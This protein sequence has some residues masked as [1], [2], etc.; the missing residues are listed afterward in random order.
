MGI[1]EKF[2]DKI[3]SYNIFTSIIP[4]CVLARLLSL[5]GLYDVQVEGTVASLVL[6]YFFGVVAGRIGSLIVES[7]LLA[8]HMINYAPRKEYIKAAQEDT[9]IKKLLEVSNMY[10]TFAGVFLLLLI[11]KAYQIVAGFLNL[12]SAV[13]G[14]L[15]VATL[16]LLFVL[17]FIKQTENMVKRVTA[18]N[19]A[20]D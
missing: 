13:T 20:S 5:L 12:S 17:S 9:D 1:L 6:Y 11:T 19:E 8:W 4:G 2:I 14:W 18:A 7:K 3:D 10:R 15:S 16:L